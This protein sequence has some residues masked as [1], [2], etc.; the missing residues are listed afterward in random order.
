MDLVLDSS[1]FFALHLMRFKIFFKASMLGSIRNILSHL[2]FGF[3]FS[4]GNIL[5]PPKSINVDESQDS[6]PAKRR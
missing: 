2:L 1:S 6:M 5:Y 3:S 4:S